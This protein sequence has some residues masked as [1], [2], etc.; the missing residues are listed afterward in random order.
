MTTK[1]LHY[2]PDHALL[3]EDTE[4]SPQID[5]ANEDLTP[6]LG[7]PFVKSEKP[8]KRP[9]AE[10]DTQIDGTNALSVVNALG[11]GSTASQF[12]VSHDTAL[13]TAI[14]IQ[15]PKS[16]LTREDLYA[17][18]QEVHTAL[19]RIIEV[20]RRTGIVRSDRSLRREQHPTR[21]GN[22]C[23]RQPVD[24][25]DLR[26]FRLAVIQFH[27]RKPK[28]DDKGASARKFDTVNMLE[29]S[30]HE[31]NRKNRGRRDTRE[32]VGHVEEQVKRRKT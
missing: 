10:F 16:E 15:Q 19:R 27:T 8:G 2:M 20:E 9:G 11:E 26:A 6:R 17:L 29:S 5:D 22:C 14:P 4:R 28:D 13:D 3:A 31:Q 12:H 32:K 24:S 7:T 23:S 30:N 21:F 1:V 25:V 18:R